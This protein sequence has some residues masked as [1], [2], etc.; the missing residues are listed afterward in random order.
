MLA[1]GYS[2]KFQLI[3]KLHFSIKDGVFG[4]A[5]LSIACLIYFAPFVLPLIWIGGWF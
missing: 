4:L 5:L 3:D 2:G 1:R